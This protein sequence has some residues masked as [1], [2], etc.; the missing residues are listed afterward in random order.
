MTIL[1]TYI[2]NVDPCVFDVLILI[3]SEITC[4]VVN[5]VYLI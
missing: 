5:F 1:S 2:S 4:Y 3:E